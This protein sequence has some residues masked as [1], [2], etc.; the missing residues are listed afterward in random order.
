MVTDSDVKSIN[1]HVKRQTKQVSRLK[2]KQ[3]AEYNVTLQLIDFFHCS[4]IYF[5]KPDTYGVVCGMQY[6]YQPYSDITSYCHHIIVYVCNSIYIYEREI[7]LT[8]YMKIKILYNNTM[9]QKVR[10]IPT[11]K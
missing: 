8:S 7:K 10:H 4:Y 3:K 6:I 5:T 1:M 2:A 9:T 11:I